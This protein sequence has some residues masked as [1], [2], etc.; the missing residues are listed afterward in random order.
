MNFPRDAHLVP[1]P[2]DEFPPKSSGAARSGMD[3]A[4]GP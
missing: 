2:L 1:A 4:M 3:E